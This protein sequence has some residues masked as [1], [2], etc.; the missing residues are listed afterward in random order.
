MKEALVIL[1]I[2]GVLFVLTAVRY[3]KQIAAGIQIWRSMKAM[4]EQIN[5]RN[6]KKVEQQPVNSGKLVNCAKCGT[7]IPEERAIKLRGGTSFC[8]TACV[9]SMAHTG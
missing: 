7:W 3:R 2:I 5:Q 8:S 4:R 6:R 1:T 9:E